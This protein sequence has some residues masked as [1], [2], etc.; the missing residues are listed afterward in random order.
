[1]EH[2]IKTRVAPSDQT[3]MTGVLGLGALAMIAVDALV[4]VRLLLIALRTRGVP[5]TMLGAAFLLIGAIGYPATT[6]ARRGVLPTVAANQLLFAT[7]LAAQDLACFAVYVFTARTFHGGRAAARVGIALGG[8]LLLASWLAQRLVTGFDPLALNAPYLLGLVARAAAFAWAAAE[9]LHHW[10]V[11]RRRL[12]IGLVA[13]ILVERFLL[14]GVGMGGVFAA[15]VA[16]A[17]GQLVTANPAESTWVLAV[18]GA[19]GL[20]A[21]VPTC[22]AFMPP[23]SYRRRFAL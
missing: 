22:L 18:T 13:P 23:A 16:F 1:M 21:S 6:M 4:G 15:F 19:A 3:R 11:A 5:E 7:G 20:L 9:S 10:R 12:A 8:L 14:F 17:I 2:R